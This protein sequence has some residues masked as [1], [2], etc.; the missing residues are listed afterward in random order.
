MPVI[1]MNPLAL[2]DLLISWCEINSGSENVAGLERMRHALA[3]ELAKL[4]D[5]SIEEVALAGTNTKALRVRVRPA[6]ARQL[7]FS[8][9]YDTVYSAEHPFQNCT[10]LDENTLRG[11]G[12]ADMKGGLIVLLAA[13]HE[14]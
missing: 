9:H 2:R 14:F 11:P 4:P 12:V 10:L 13:L 7:F 8:G 3:A 5:A 1:A 6:A